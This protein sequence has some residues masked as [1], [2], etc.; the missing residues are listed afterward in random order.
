VVLA[1]RLR[2]ALQAGAG[3]FERAVDRFD[4]RVEHVG[5][6]VGV[7]PEDFAQD[8]HGALA[9]GQDLKGR[10]EGERDGLGLFVTCLGAKRQVDRPLEEGVGVWLEPRDFAQ[11]GRLGRFNE[12]LDILV[13]NAGIAL[14]DDL[15]DRGAL[16]Q[17]LAVNLFGT[18]GVTQACLP[19]LTRSHGAIV[20]NVSLMAFA[21]LPL[22]AAYAISKAAAFNMTQ[23]WR[24]LLP[25]GASAFTPS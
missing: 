6:L 19:L 24:A 13:N 4:R 11:P 17:H 8:E 3:P 1:H 10:H 25:G 18:H 15:S 5:H 20:N 23:S 9:S 16:E 2:A 7:I 21:P 12:S 22:T 14:Y